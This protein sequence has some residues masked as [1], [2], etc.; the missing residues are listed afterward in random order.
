MD[1]GGPGL[2]PDVAFEILGEETRLSILRAVWAAD[3]VP[4]A[5]SVL[6][7]AVGSPDSG[8]FNYHLGKLDGPFLDS[9]GDG[10]TLTQAGREVVRAVMAGTVTVA[11]SV[12]STT[13]DGRCPTCGGVLEI[14]YDDQVTVACG[15]CGG[16]VMWNEF[17]PA[18]LADRSPS[19]IAWAFDR[20]VR[21]RFQLA[22]DGICPNCASDME[23]QLDGI[24]PDASDDPETVASLHTCPTCRY[25]ARVPLAGHALS[26][27]AVIAF[28]WE[29]EVDLTT[30]PYWEWRE[31]FQNFT[32]TVADTDPYTFQVAI[33][34]DH[35]TL[36]L[37]FDAEL[38]VS[39]VER[40]G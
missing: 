30:L 15:D 36:T 9:T 31:R 34:A 24:T 26:H 20:W 39:A 1:A 5:F 11:P 37:T 6:R 35:G 23:K 19:D 18:G 25:E 16:T 22:A 32:T 7:R 3:T 38:D 10:Y 8:R 28:F 29:M 14:R 12:P 13:I 17:P 27:P 33:P 40:S 21:R 4:V 2:S